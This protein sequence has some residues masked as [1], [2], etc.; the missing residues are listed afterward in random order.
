MSSN[1]I[2]INCGNLNIW[3]V[4]ILL[5]GLI[6]QGCSS[7]LDRLP[8]DFSN[9]QKDKEVVIG[10]RSASYGSWKNQLDKLINRNEDFD[11]ILE[12]GLSLIN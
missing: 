6:F 4:V 2:K 9:N 11:F 10:L 1:L 3:M 12:Q 8:E 5:L 7:E